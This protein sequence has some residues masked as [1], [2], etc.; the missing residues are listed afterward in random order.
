[1]FTPVLLACSF[2]FLF[3]RRRQGGADSNTNPL[4]SFSISFGS[5]NSLSFFE[6]TRCPFSIR[7]TRLGRRDQLCLAPATNSFN[8]LIYLFNTA[9]AYI[10]II[11]KQSSQ[12]MV[13]LGAA[14]AL[15]VF[16]ASAVLGQ[17][18]SQAGNG[19]SGGTSCGAGSKCPANLP[20]CSRK[21]LYLLSNRQD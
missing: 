12:A 21:Y 1:M 10:I 11:A 8:D 14:A 9:S 6:C 16:S 7:F 18:S 20:C 19:A 5:R 17:S 3:L 4:H 2:C 15:A 13:H